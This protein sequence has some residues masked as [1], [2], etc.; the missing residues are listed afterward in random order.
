[1]IC[2]GE[3]KSVTKNFGFVIPF[4]LSGV[5]MAQPTASEVSPK[6]A[7]SFFTQRGKIVV[8]FVGYSG[9]GYEDAEAMLAEA[10]NALSVHSPQKTIVNIG[11]TSSGIGQVY[12]VAKKMGF[13][14]TGIVSTQAKKH[15]A[16][17]SPH[18]DTVFYVED[19]TW[20]GFLENT[21]QLSPTSQ[22]MVECSD[23]IIGIGGGAVSRDEMIAANRQSKTVKFIP[24]DMNH[25]IAIEEARK[26]NQRAPSDFRGAVYKALGAP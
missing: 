25:K 16:E 26:T 10:R 22:V 8:T 23:V 13:E 2:R 1:M 15:K 21:E 14:T 5:V 6:E 9:A 11:A 18:V 12:T 19:D 17:I 24:A 20:G 4:V 7:K 3:E